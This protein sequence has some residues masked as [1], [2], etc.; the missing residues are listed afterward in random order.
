MHSNS[1]LANRTDGLRGQKISTSSP[2]LLHTGYM[3][4]T[5]LEEHTAQSKGSLGTFV[6]G[7]PGESGASTNPTETLQLGG[8]V[9]DP[10]GNPTDETAHSGIL[11]IRVKGTENSRLASSLR[12]I[13]AGKLLRIEGSIVLAGQDEVS[14]DYRTELNRLRSRLEL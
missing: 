11:V 4:K 10:H 1:G 8:T 3:A 6:S 9:P 12:A 14:R 7:R 2:Q 5:W 13:A